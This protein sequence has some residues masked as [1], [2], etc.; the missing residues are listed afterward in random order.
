M[1]YS[2]ARGTLASRTVR[3]EQRTRAWPDLA[4]GKCQ[5]HGCIKSPSSTARGAA[6][7]HTT[8]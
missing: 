5:A 2:H 8:V 1:Q 7:L 3:K 4:G 6:G